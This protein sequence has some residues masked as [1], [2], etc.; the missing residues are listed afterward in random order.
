MAN[1]RI[2]LADDHELIRTGMRNL[3]GSNSD[4]QIVGEAA[5]GE[6]TIAKVRQLRP[7]VAIVD[8]SMPKLSGIE[9]AKRICKEFP[10]VRVLVL[11]MHENAEY[12]YQILKSGAS[13]YLLKNAGKD[14]ITQAIYAVMK[15]NK[16]FSPRIS[17]LMISEYVK[18]AEKRD[19]RSEE[20]ILTRREE[21]VLR[22]IARGMNNQQIA[23]K[24]FI[25]PRTVETHRTNIMQKLNIHDAP[26]LVRYALENGYGRE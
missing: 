18:K 10:S 8:I 26:N 24:L 7:D 9:A 3:I 20:A 2:L 6:D 14:E 5:D 23:E 15:G 1:I 11:T 17:D 22:Y 19:E 21:E 13:G 16:F 12:V 4:F 25:S